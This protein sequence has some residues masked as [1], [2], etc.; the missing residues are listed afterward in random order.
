M[1]GIIKYYFEKIYPVLLSIVCTII[2]L[3]YKLNYIN[4]K[5]I[6]NVA[7]GIITFVSLIIGFI[8]A[9]LPVVL[10]VKTESDFVKN[11]FMRGNNLFVKYLKSTLLFGVLTIIVSILI[12]FRN[13]YINSE[14]YNYVFYLWTFI[15]IS[16]VLMIYRF[17]SNMI[18]IIFVPEK[19]I[20]DNSQE[21]TEFEKQLEH[22][23]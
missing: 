23:N 14:F 15:F 1:I 19:I 11:I 20:T 2:M 12:Y 3:Y 4:S 5:N 6:D 9:V 22:D 13:E 7:E 21:K 17:F 18:N 8:G 16:F 10:T